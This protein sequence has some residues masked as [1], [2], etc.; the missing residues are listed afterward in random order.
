MPTANQIFHAKI[1]KVDSTS[2]INWGD[3]M[4][5]SPSS[6]DKGVGGSSPI[7]DFSLNIT[8]SPNQMI[9]PDVIDQAGEVRI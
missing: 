2:T 6:N 3:T 9:D 4:N 1:G 8:G 5:V 7:G